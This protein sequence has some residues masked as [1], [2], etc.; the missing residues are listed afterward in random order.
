[1]NFYNSI[2]KIELHVHLEG[3]IPLES[4][5]NLIQK[6]DGSPEVSSLSDLKNKFVFKDFNHFIETWIWKNRFLREYED[7]TYIAEQV[8]SDMVSQNIKYAEVFISPSDFK[9]H[10]LNC[11][12]IVQAVHEGINKVNNIKIQLIV[13][14]VRDFGSE[15]AMRTLFEINEVKEYSVIGIGIGGSEN[16]YPP[17]LFCDVYKKARE[18]GFRTTAHAGEASGQE[19]IWGAIRSLHV[20]R[21]G[22]GTKSVQDIK[23]LEYLSENKIPLELC[24]ISNVRTNVIDSYNDYPIRKFIEYAIPFSINT[25]DPKMFGNS[26]AEEYEMLEKHFNFTKNE[27]AGFIINSINTSWLNN[28]EKDL[29]MRQFRDEINTLFVQSS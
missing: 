4:L 12:K 25:D 21:I 13:D 28:K 23:L 27:I 3:A 1:M 26:L 19:S 9:K 10:G 2:P 24:P 7:F 6:Y 8:A 17:E 29:L 20:D 11:K 16:K 22:H 5:W 15:N 18:L 14:L